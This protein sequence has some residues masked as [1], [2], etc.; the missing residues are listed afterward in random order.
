MRGGNG[1][2]RLV[3]RDA[4]PRLVGRGLELAAAA[5]A[6][7]G[8]V[9]V[10]V[11]GEPGIGKSRVLGELRRD[12]ERAGWLVAAGRATDHGP[13][14]AAVADALTPAVLARPD[15]LDRLPAPLA[16]AVAQVLPALPPGSGAS[17][18]PPYPASGHHHACLA[19]VALLESL[20]AER[21][22]LLLLDDLH[23]AD[24]ATVELVDHLL[25]HQPAGR[26]LLAVAYRPRQVTGRLA[27]VLDRAVADG[28]ARHVRLG[29]L[30]IA[31]T[32]ELAGLPTTDGG[33][34]DS[35][36][37]AAR[38]HAATGG[39]PLY[40]T[41][42]A[43]SDST[44]G[45]ESESPDT[46]LSPEVLAALGADLERLPT[47]A[48]TVLHAAAVLG[49]EVDVDPLP[50]VADLPD[51]TVWTAVDEL[52]AAD[53]LR[54]DGEPGRLRFRHPLLRDVVHQSAGIGWR[55]A[56]HAR[57][58]R[59]LTARAAPAD[60][61]A[62]HVARAATPG[63][64]TA[65][66]VLL[67]AAAANR[68]QAPAT[69]AQWY[70]T[71]LRLLPVDRRHPA[72]RGR[73]LLAMA[74]CLL[75]AGRL[76]ESGD[77]ATEALQLLRRR[78]RPVVRRAVR[79]AAAVSHL[80]GRTD[81]AAALLRQ[82]IGQPGLAD[83]G[84]LLQ[85]ASIELLRG[86]LRAAWTL[87]GQ[88]RAD[89]GSVDLGAT[90]ILAFVHA[91]AGDAAGAT[92]AADAAG[93]LLDTACAATLVA[94]L[95]SA[96]WLMWAEVT[97]GRYQRALRLQ[98]RAVP[99]CRSAGSENLLA[100]WLVGCAETARRLGR[101]DRAGRFAEEAADVARRSGASELT[102]FAVTTQCRVA[103]SAGDAGAA[104]RFAAEIGAT[105]PDRPGVFGALAGAVAAEASLLAGEPRD[106]VTGV[107]VAGGG[108]AL[109]TFD[110]SSRA[111]LYELLT[112][113]ELAAGRVPDARRWAD[114]A[115]EV[116]RAGV[117]AVG[118]GHAEL[119][120]AQVQLATDRPHDAAAAAA[121]AVLCLDEPNPLVAARAR[122]VQ[123]RALAT[124]G[125]RTEAVDALLAADE[126]ATRCGAAGLRDELAT[127]LRRL[128]MR[129]RRPAP[130]GPG[131]AGLQALSERERQIAQLA[132]GGGT[133]RSI[134]ATLFLSEKTIERHLS[135]AFT[136]LGVSSRTALATKV[137]TTA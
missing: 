108:A 83:S 69:A 14:F 119:A 67:G 100:Q 127:E 20:A 42:L 107:L 32:A 80:R 77:A 35:G 33:V 4:E 64:E 63:D 134:A 95:P 24:D 26:V 72:R 58:A 128:G 118:A 23:L 99:L 18:P 73:L 59:L 19:A 34:A 71:A 101:L 117:L 98:D 126:T 9:A 68:W 81:E 40:V 8:D 112:R 52:M 17:A 89:N 121:L 15:L 38:L 39:N 61:L 97:L 104:R 76:S 90:A 2:P 106:C 78:A 79:T 50:T 45:S 91:S 132:A 88:A 66:R 87:A 111:W 47:V 65:I 129:V 28:R 29:P 136:K 54:A 96:V 137:A 130:R 60:V 120:A 110:P 92:A 109:A 103:I 7:H 25:R 57:A 102:L 43:G 37:T 13:P 41:A 56:A 62:G 27:A 1:A 114:L 55:R 75:A 31:Q 105:L 10:V 94:H 70:E 74:E 124:L 51:H 21:P 36:G 85:L 116:D 46:P 3:G 135:S 53:L 122:L 44:T 48:R 6:L 5:A 86:D 115:A 12:A 133:N 22:V 123:A 16:G 82:A 125:R 49:T 84:L 11:S 113:A 93:A 30:T 131:G